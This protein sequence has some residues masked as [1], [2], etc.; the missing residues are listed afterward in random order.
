M[1]EKIKVIVRG[2]QI[3]RP[4]FRLIDL[5]VALSILQKYATMIAFISISWLC[6]TGY[7]L[8]VWSVDCWLM[9]H[10]AIFQLS[11][12][13]YKWFQPASG[14][15]RHEQLWAFN[16]Q[17]LTLKGHLAPKNLFAIIMDSW[18]LT[19][20]LSICSPQRIPNVFARRL[21]FL[22]LYKKSN[23]LQNSILNSLLQKNYQKKNRASIEKNKIKTPLR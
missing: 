3:R 14:H 19:V 18:D 9:S 22:N 12:D 6:C 7:L 23:R 20:D 21:M 5:I 17:I 15:Q 10:S 1:F 2:L 4:I 16:I 13:K 8:V 11:D